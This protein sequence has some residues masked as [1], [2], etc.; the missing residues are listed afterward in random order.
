LALELL[1]SVE[2]NHV[3]GEFG[4]VWC[5]LHYLA[6]L[7]L[8]E[9]QL[10]QDRPQQAVYILRPMGPKPESIDP[11]RPSY[12]AMRAHVLARAHEMLN[13]PIQAQ[14]NW[15][16][17]QHLIEPLGDTALEI[18]A[19]CGLARGF[20]NLGD[21]LESIDAARQALAIARTQHDWEWQQEAAHILGRAYL[22]KRD[23]AIAATFL[24]NAL[25]LAEQLGNQ[26]AASN[27]LVD[28][29]LALGAQHQELEA[30]FCLERAQTMR[31]YL[32]SSHAAEIDRCM[33]NWATD[34]PT[35]A[36]Q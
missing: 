19:L 23:H 26:M 1:D 9:A 13:S 32:S 20:L 18:D 17:L 22:G 3:N 12:A 16:E 31:G 36:S 24:M 8:A 11:Y 5:G 6:Q 10:L 25:C 34:T 15:E 33:R 35:L 21:Y 7:G 27:A 4:R 28:L 2:P 29:G 14:H 30:M